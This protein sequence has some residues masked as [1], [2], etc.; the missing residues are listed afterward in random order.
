MAEKEQHR[1]E[2]LA[3]IEENRQRRMR[4]RQREWEQEERERIKLVRGGGR[5]AGMTRGGREGEGVR[6][7]RVMSTRSD[8]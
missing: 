2:L 8:H 6:T 1:L 7:V 5:E 3:Q 4:E